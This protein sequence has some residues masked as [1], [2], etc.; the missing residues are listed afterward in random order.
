MPRRWFAVLLLT[1]LSFPARAAESLPD[2]K[3]LTED[4]DLAAKMVEGI[5][6][7]LMRELAASIDKRKQYWKPDFSSAEAYDKSVQPNRERLKKI[8]GVVDERVP[9]T[10]LEYVGGPKTPSLVAETDDYKVFAV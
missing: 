6:K 5:D 9:F 3:P 10:D 2:T 4:G 8:L 1:A 7:Y